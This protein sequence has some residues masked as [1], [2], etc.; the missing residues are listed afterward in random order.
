M[1]GTKGELCNMLALSF[2]ADLL[3]ST[4]FF[5]NLSCCTFRNITDE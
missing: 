1:R 5:A 2:L 3:G 4:A